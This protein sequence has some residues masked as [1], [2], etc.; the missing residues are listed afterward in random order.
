M[1]NG[2]LL[3]I[4]PL[5]LKF[6]L[7]LK[8]SVSCSLQLSNKTEGH[9]AFKVK[10]TN[11]KKYCV[12]PNTGVIPPLST[13]A[14]IV[15]M[16]TLKEI[17]ADL[18]CKD[19][20][21]VQSIVANAGLTVK[22]ITAEMFSKDSGNAVEDCKLKVVHLSAPQ[23][24]SPV[25]EGSEEGLSP[26]NSLSENNGSSAATVLLSAPRIF[27]EPREKSPDESHRTNLA[28]I[29]NLTNEKNRTEQ[30]NIELRKEL[31]LLRRAVASKQSGG[32]SFLFALIIGLMGILLGYIVR[33]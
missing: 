21:L 31:E 28:T 17:P 7:E 30:E 33:K 5:E 11:P 10:T 8:K 18:N 23:P 26:R 22:D 2:E 1:A 19:K 12:R 3:E 6:H 29:S 4:E 20:F 32:F 9:V 25:P 16:Q 15:T 13:C 24:P 14:V 27:N